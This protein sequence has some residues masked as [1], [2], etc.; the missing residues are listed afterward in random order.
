[1]LIAKTVNPQI[2]SRHP[3]L[4]EP[5]RAFLVPSPH[6]IIRYAYYAFI[7]S[8]PLQGLDV[9]TALVSST[10]PKLIGMMFAGLAFIQFRV[11]F[12]PPPPA[13]W[14]FVGYLCFFTFYTGYLILTEG[15]TIDVDTDRI[16][17]LLQM[18][19]LFWTSY[20]LL[21]YKEVSRGT[22]LVFSISCVLVAVLAI[23]G[24]ATEGL[25]RTRATIGTVNPNTISAMICLGLLALTGLAYGGQKPERRLRLL[26]WL[27]LLPMVLGIVRSG[28]R[29]ALV[30][31]IPALLIFPLSRGNF[32][33]KVK[34]GLIVLVGLV[35]MAVI[36]YQIE[37]IRIRWEK[38]FFEGEVAGRVEIY[39]EAWKLFTEKP[40][41]GWGPERH[42]RELG[43]RL[44]LESRDTHNLYLWLLTQVGL[45]GAI[46]FLLGTWFCWMAAWLTRKTPQGCLASAFLLFFLIVNLKGTY[47]Y[48]KFFWVTLAFAAASP[49]AAASAARSYARLRAFGKPSRSLH[50]MRPRFNDADG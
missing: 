12:K 16:F 44:G 21:Q 37:P 25:E 5:A 23:T 9:G 7:F 13:F 31:L 20:N 26:F 1:M 27:C 49:A 18:F 24:I 30:A 41:L 4:K 40:W 46:P 3:S 6:W 34:L 48:N 10:F 14:W 22:L 32:S 2:A 45:I 19:V 15:D 17:S 43:L 8:L 50:S 28:S 47:I 39:D 38:T 11:C 33:S 42:T 35:L 36:S 29:G